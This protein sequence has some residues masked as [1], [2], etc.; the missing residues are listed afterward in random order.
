VNTRRRSRDTAAEILIVEDS[1]TQ[2]LHLQYILEQ[3]NYRASV[4]INGRNALAG[5]RQHKPII[6]ISDVLMPE[7]D[8]Y[9][10]CQQIKAD[11]NLADIPVI[12]LTSLSDPKDVIK[13]LECGADNFIMKPYDE[14]FLLSRIQSILAN[15]RGRHV[16]RTQMGLEIFFAGQTYFIT[17]DRLQILNLL[18]STYETAVQKNR[19]LIEAQDTLQQLNAHLEEI[20]AERTGALTVEIAERQRAEEAL[21]RYAERLRILQEIDRAILAAQSPEAIAQTAVGHISTLVPCWRVGIWLFDWQTRQGLVLAVTGRDTPSIPVGMH[22]ALEAHGLQDLAV[23]EAGQVYVVEDIRT[24]TP[25]PATVQA[26]QAEGL[27]SY[28]RVPLE[29]QGV[30]IG[31]LNLWSDQLG[32]FTAE[33]VDIA[34]E[35]ADQ[36][37]IGIQQARLHEQVQRH[38]ADLEQRVAER[39]AELRQNNAELESF[40]YSVSH[41]LRAPLR[42]MQG[43]AQIFLE[44]YNDRLDAVGRDYLQRIVA[45]ARRMDTLTDD[46][47]T[48]TRLSRIAVELIPVS[49]EEV[50]DGAL[51]QLQAEIRAKEAQVT[52]ARPLPQVIGHYVTVVQAVANLLANGLKFVAPGVRPQ[53][54]VWAEERDD[55]VCL[56]LRDNGIGIAPEYQERIFRIFERL[57]G[58][59][60]Y[61]GTGIGLSLVR[62][63][64]ERIGGQVG[65][66]SVPGQGST[67][68]LELRRPPR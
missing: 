27:Q 28:V 53:V 67:F 30:L 37:A 2:A 57:H 15:Q 29:V 58:P 8:G 6:V 59:E 60:T 50:V 12:L 46:L 11:A 51:M 41:D 17:S 3:H 13:G 5:M 7:M 32:A 40:S 31:S 45:A 48:Y 34:R 9:Q 38:A 21:R 14:D 1:P 10:L 68:W 44:E 49:L 20:V 4:A 52:V 47:L 39:T 62:K 26:L 63:G 61:P 35:V 23:L 66:E 19:Q 16:E 43:F 22:I 25:L 55:S 65:V 33:Q 64:M 56:R 54:H 24:L 42:S 36:L 18:L